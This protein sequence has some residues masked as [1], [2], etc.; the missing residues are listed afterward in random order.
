M[1]AVVQSAPGGVD[2]LQLDEIAPP[3]R[4]AGQLLLRVMA[5]GINRADLAQRAGHYPPPPGASPILGLEVAGVVEEAD[6]D[7]RFRPGDAVFGLIG[8]GGYAEYA[9]LDEALA[10]AKPD[11]L[12]WVEAASLPEA[13]MTAWFNLVEKA[14]LQAGETVLVHAG[15]SGVGAAAIQLAGLL[16]AQAFASAG[17]EEKAAFCR[18]LGAAQAFNYRQTPAFGALVKDWGG[19]DVVLDPVGASYLNDNLSA[20]KPDGRLVNI[21]LLGGAKAE[22]NLGAL[23]MKR[24]SLIGSTLRPQPLEVKARLARAV[25]ARILPALEQGRLRLTL[26]SSYPVAQVADAHAYVEANRNLGKVVLTLFPVLAG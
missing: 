18:Q 21:G 2:T 10:I 14:G 26:D 9:L 8:G 4:G 16:G 15:A 7:S 22:L 3:L 25:E 20:L 23:L 17:S 11:W 5:A 24:I 1:L 12:S 19:A 6:A 13:W